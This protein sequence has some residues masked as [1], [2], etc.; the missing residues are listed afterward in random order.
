M[1]S[2]DTLPT[3]IAENL[4]RIGD[5]RFL[6]IVHEGIEDQHYTYRQLW[7]TQQRWAAHYRHHGIAPRG[8][9]I[10]ILSHG[11]S[12][13]GAIGGALLGGF[14]PSVFAVPSVKISEEYYINNICTLIAQSEA[15]VIVADDSIANK[16]RPHLFAR[17]IATPVIPENPRNES[18]VDDA[19]YTG[20]PDDI[21]FLQY[22]SGTTG[23]RKGVAI[24]HRALLW[25]VD[26]YARALELQH[27]DIIA[28]WLPLYH[29]MG[30]VACWLLPW[31]TGTRLISMSAF[32][33]VQRPALLLDKITNYR[34]TLCWLPNFAYHHTV[35]HIERTEQPQWTLNS[36]RM[37]INCSEPIGASTHANFQR[38]LAN[39]GV[40]EAQLGSCYAMAETTFA[41]TASRPGA[42]ARVERVDATAFAIKKM[43]IPAGPGVAC[44]E[45]VSSGAALPGVEIQI[46][47]DTGQKLDEHHVG[48]LVVQ[49]PSL[50]KGYFNNVEE[51][52]RVL[53]G[54]GF[55]TGDLGYRANGEYF[56][57]GRKKD[58]IIVAG[59]NIYPHDI[60]QE[61][62]AIDGVIPGRCVA[63]GIVDQHSGTE[64][65]VVIVES[66]R[67]TIAENC[68]EIQRVI[69]SC[70][71][72]HVDVTPADVRI[73]EPG[74]LI[75]SSSGK[76]ARI[77]TREKYIKNFESDSNK[78]DKTTSENITGMHARDRVW[79]ALRSALA[80]PT[81][82]MVRDDE[83]PLMTSGLLDSL[84]FAA[85]LV[86]L[87]K[88]FQVALP[89]TTLDD[90]RQFDSVK[91]ITALMARLTRVNSPQ[92]NGATTD[93]YAQAA[94]QFV[95]GEDLRKYRIAPQLADAD[96]LPAQ[97]DPQLGIISLANFRSE[98][99]NTDAQG[100]RCTVRDGCTLT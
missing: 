71:Q 41:I 64:K 53:G 2:L 60:E 85:L 51:S 11:I 37:F 39:F 91:N 3:R 80:G 4:R 52:R 20:D 25:Q 62:N 10:I 35:T 32:D 5:T 100:F 74:W 69:F 14:V 82:A 34:A 44:K 54:E 22:S 7:E 61:L 59:K 96:R 97:R 89:P 40:T 70:V 8:T 15:A 36:M 24:S 77:L 95:A 75:K 90:A 68:G 73:V 86:A 31:L 18:G 42:V 78:V 72:S 99:L 12:L 16:L 76:I 79:V 58:V 50:F 23:L 9:V 66:Q 45:F 21:A 17:H 63:F 48:E 1:T 49:S 93:W 57:V 88:T 29:D 43:A 30:L 27:S 67:W 13:Y 65:I 46:L 84:S 33:W 98:T 92:E 38:A 81:I 83:T 87:E 6:T 26:R 94:R 47:D 56:I 19:M 28:S 55:F